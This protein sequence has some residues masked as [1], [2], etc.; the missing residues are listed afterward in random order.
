M[1]EHLCGVWLEKSDGFK[2]REGS[3]LELFGNLRSQ[4]VLRAIKGAST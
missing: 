1:W 2:L 4:T 3:N